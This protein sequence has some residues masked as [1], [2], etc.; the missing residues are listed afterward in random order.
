MRLRLKKMDEYLVISVLG[1]DKP[2][3]I[4]QLA[5]VVLDNECNILDTRMTVLGEEFAL[6]MMISGNNQ[7]IGHR[8]V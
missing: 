8:G 5:S 4:N 6:I 3:I 7:S 2:G 1:T